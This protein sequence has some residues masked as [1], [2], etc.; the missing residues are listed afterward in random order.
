MKNNT[1]HV[2]RSRYFVSKDGS[3]RIRV[4]TGGVDIE[5]GY[6]RNNLRGSFGDRWLPWKSGQKPTERRKLVGDGKLYVS[7]PN[8]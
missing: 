2:Q 7:R 6:K 1:K 3:K 4:V 5:T 8:I